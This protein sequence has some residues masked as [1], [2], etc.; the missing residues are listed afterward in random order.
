MP[1]SAKF[2]PVVKASLMS[3]IPYELLMLL[4]LLAS[5]YYTKTRQI[6]K[7][8]RNVL[9]AALVCLMPLAG[10]FNLIA[11]DYSV[12]EIGLSLRDVIKGKEAVI[13]YHVNYPSMYFYTLRNSVLINSKLNLG[14]EEKKFT[15]EDSFISASWKRKDRCFL[16]LPEDDDVKTILPKAANNIYHISRAEGMLLLSNQ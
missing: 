3:L 7:W 5:W 1:F 12:K 8:V 15:A 11:E 6:K 16:V 14:I 9:G 2:F 4:F 10:V 13:Q